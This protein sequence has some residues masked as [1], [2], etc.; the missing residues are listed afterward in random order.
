MKTDLIK[1]IITAMCVAVIV[2][3]FGAMLVGCYDSYEGELSVDYPTNILQ[4]VNVAPD[5]A[6]VASVAVDIE[7]ILNDTTL[8]DNEKIRKVMDGLEE[9]ESKVLRYAYFKYTKGNTKIDDANN[10]TLIDQRLKKQD[11]AAKDD[12][13]LKLPINNGTSTSL[14][15]FYA[16]TVANGT[17]GIFADGDLWRLKTDLDNVTYNYDQKGLLTVADDAWEKGSD[18]GPN[19]K[20]NGKDTQNREEAKKTAINFSCANIISSEGITIEHNDEEGYYTLKFKADVAVANADKTTVDKLANDNKPASNVKYNLLEYT[21][22]VW[23]CGLFRTINTKENWSGS[24]IGM[25]SDAD[26]EMYYEF[27]YSERDLDHSKTQAII[28]RLDA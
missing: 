22:T 25:E 26:V 17:K 13:I 2:A 5:E 24:F 21:V 23:D 27:S 4:D 9:N 19:G 11:A 28:D 8:A 20:E 3:T 7:A 1:K 18:W 10:F 15:N 16:P 14:Y 6:V 12:I